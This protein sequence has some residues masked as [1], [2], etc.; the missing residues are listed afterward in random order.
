MSEQDMNELSM[1]H[2]LSDM[3]NPH[4][5]KCDNCFIEKKNKT[6]F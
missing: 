6:S 1:R 4:L 5:M 3:R 2:V